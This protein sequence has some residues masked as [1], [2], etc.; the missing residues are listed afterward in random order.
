[1]NNYFWQNICS[2]SVIWSDSD[3]E[4]VL[5]KTNYTWKAFLPDI[6]K[7]ETFLSWYLRLCDNFKMTP[8]K[9]INSEKR[10][11]YEYK[12]IEL[13]L[14]AY[15]YSWLWMFDIKELPINFEE[16]LIRR[17]MKFYPAEHQIKSPVWLNDLVSNFD[18]DME[19]SRQMIYVL[20]T[21]LSY[22]PTC[23]EIQKLKYFRIG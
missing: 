12:L 6:F 13:N 22:C 5:N 1:M 23:W 2:S 15:G 4:N 14:I 10:F 17:D 8:S 19:L 11:W 21:E 16:S 3:L 9:I 20:E 7:D 18:T